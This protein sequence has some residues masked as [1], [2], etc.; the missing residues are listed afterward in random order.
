MAIYDPVTGEI[1]NGP[2]LEDELDLDIDKFNR[3][4]IT[5][6]FNRAVLAEIAREIDP[7]NPEEQGKTLIY[8]V[9]DQHA[10]LI[11]KILK[12]IYGEIGVDNDAI[13]KITGSIEGGNKKMNT[14]LKE[15]T[16]EEIA[17]DII[18]LIRRFAIGST[19]M[20]HEERIQKAVARLKKAH[21]FSK[22]ELSW[23]SRMEKY[24]LEET[25]LQVEVFDE[26]SRFKAQGGFD[27]L[28]KIFRHQL[29]NIVTELNDYPYDDG[30]NA[31]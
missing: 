4:V 16:S 11:V 29:A 18:T 14:A 2:L 3:Q 24:L 10:D 27:R 23:L 9:N 28:D 19:L 25:V 6:S 26:D 21:T 17:A 12:E 31:A 22:Q 13:L 20:S 30:G 1:T 8:A 15:T 7:E 5:E